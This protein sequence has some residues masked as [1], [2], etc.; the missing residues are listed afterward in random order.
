MSE[1]H[2]GSSGQ[3]ERRQAFADGALVVRSRKGVHPSE[4]ALLNALPKGRGGAALV[5][6]TTETLAGLA[7][8][9]L[10]PEAVVHC[11]FDDTWDL[12]AA[13]Q[14]A[15]QHPSLPV[16]LAV[17]PDPPEGPYDL[18]VLPFTATGVADLVHER[19]AFALKRLTPNGLLFTSSDNRNDRFLRDAVIGLFGSATTVPGPTR[20]SGVAYVARR[21]K[22]PKL[23][24]RDFRR[25]FTVKDVGAPLVGAPL[26]AG[27]SPAPTFVSRPGVFCHGR[28]DA[29]TRALLAALDVGEATRILDLGCGVGVLGLVAALRC[30]SARVTLVDSHA[31]AIECTQANAASLG[32]QDRCTAVLSADALRDVAPGPVLS[33]AEGY[34]LVLS[35]PPYYGNYRI[36]EMFLDTATRVLLPGGRIVLVTRGPKWFADA[37]EGRFSDLT[38]CESQGYWVIQATQPAPAEGKLTCP[39]LRM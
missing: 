7:L 5:A 37:M 2:L 4:E 8:K 35:N 33:E 36:A 25:T 26:G 31:R 27:T 15:G 12:E 11:H 14:T 38:T 18:V 16:T 6:N 1:I 23:R 20:R 17:A 13:Q 34:D 28:L 22:E 39:T 3:Q 19:L 9:A 30:P 32:L 10:N 29:G 21:P 24:E